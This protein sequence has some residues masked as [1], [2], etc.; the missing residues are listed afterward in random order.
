VFTADQAAKGKALF[1]AKCAICHGAELNGAEMTPP[2]AGDEAA[3]GQVA[4]TAEKP[5]GK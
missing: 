1:E 3:L 4:I 5:A 2:L